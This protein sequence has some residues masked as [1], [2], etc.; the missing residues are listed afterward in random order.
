MQRGDLEEEMGLTSNPPSTDE[1]GLLTAGN[2]VSR[3]DLSLHSRNIAGISVGAGVQ[4]GPGTYAPTAWAHLGQKRGELT[5]L[6][7]LWEEL[8]EGVGGG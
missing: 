2:S 5:S 4:L 3:N 8:G 1:P 6:G 7:H